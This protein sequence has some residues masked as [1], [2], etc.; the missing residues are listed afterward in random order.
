MH[1]YPQDLVDYLTEQESEGNE[2][3]ITQNDDSTIFIVVQKD[4]KDW[5]SIIEWYEGEDKY[6]HV[7]ICGKAVSRF[8][9]VLKEQEK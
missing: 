1:K 4:L 5:Y 3:F 8:R 6:N 9:K 7:N 2:I